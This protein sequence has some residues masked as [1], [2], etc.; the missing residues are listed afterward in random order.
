MALVLGDS[1]VTHGF[2]DKEGFGA[3]LASHFFGKL[4]FIHRGYSGYSSR[5]IAHYIDLIL[6]SVSSK[7]KVVIVWVGAN[8]ACLLSSGSSQ[9]CP[10]DEYYENIKSIFSSIEAKL[11]AVAQVVFIGPP[12]IN[13]EQRLVHQRNKYGEYATGV[14]ERT[15]A[16]TRLYADE[17]CQVVGLSNKIVHIHLH[18]EIEKTKMESS[19]FLC[20]GLHLSEY[21][22]EFVYGLIVGV[23]KIHNIFQLP[24]ANQVTLHPPLKYGESAQCF[25]NGYFWDWNSSS[26]KKG[27]SL[28]VENGMIVDVVK[29]VENAKRSTVVDLEGLFVTP[30]FCY[31][32]NYPGTAGKAAIIELTESSIASFLDGV[33]RKQRNLLLTNCQE[34]EMDLIQ[35]MARTGVIAIVEPS[36]I[37][38]ASYGLKTL[39]KS[40]ILVAAVLEESQNPFVGMYHAICGGDESVSFAQALSLYTISAYVST[41]MFLRFK[42]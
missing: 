12:P 22:N 34:L 24:S 17:L 10:V 2:S 11:P 38:N 28:I 3:R 13:E 6:D 35:R 15:A 20:D 18:E 41:L 1:L 25:T 4:D 21:G 33:D 27:T 16:N 19:R 42:E 36:K 26:Y 37:G 40:G 30:G 5:W 9:F 29:D 23:L 7:T 8:D 39:I 31:I 32:K 14:L